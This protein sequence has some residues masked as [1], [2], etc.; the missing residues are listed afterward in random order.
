MMSFSELRIDSPT[1]VFM[2]YLYLSTCTH[3]GN[4]VTVITIL[5][6]TYR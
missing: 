3:Q 2:H 4:F 6:A 5:Q 1:A